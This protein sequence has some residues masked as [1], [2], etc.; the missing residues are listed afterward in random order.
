MSIV[1]HPAREANS[2]RSRLSLGALLSIGRD[3]SGARSYRVLALLLL[4][5][6]AGAALGWGAKDDLDDPFPLRRILLPVEKLPAALERLGDGVLV[7]LPR[8]EFEGLVRQAAKARVEK[9]SP[10]LVE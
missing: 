3:P 9:Q 7:R 8:K 1:K 2:N 10:Q 6:A 5:V 4:F